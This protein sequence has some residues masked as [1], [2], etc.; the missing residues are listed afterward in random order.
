LY[1]L[2]NITEAYY[3]YTVFSI[4]FKKILNTQLSSKI[5]TQFV[6][7]IYT[8]LFYFIFELKNANKLI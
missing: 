2:L 4:W 8:Q 5:L 7:V 6:A 3:L 1:I